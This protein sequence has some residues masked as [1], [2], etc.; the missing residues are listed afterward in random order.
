MLN[1]ISALLLLYSINFQDPS[2]FWILSANS[3]KDEY[4]FKS[5]YLKKVGP[6]ITIWLKRVPFSPEESDGKMLYYELQLQEC[7]CN[8]YSYRILSLNE[9]DENGGTIKTFNFNEKEDNYAA[10]GSV[11]YQYINDICN[12]FNKKKK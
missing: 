4:F 11:G 6:K 7:N 8:N 9:Y 5:K 3:T 12:R 1:F 2:G 10:P